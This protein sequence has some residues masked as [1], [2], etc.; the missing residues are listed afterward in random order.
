M[1]RSF[2]P[3]TDQIR[4]RVYGSTALPQ[5]AAA[6]FGSL[7]TLAAA[8]PIGEE[9]SGTGTLANAVVLVYKLLRELGIDEADIDVAAF[10]AL[11][12]TSPAVGLAHPA[13]AVSEEK[14]N[15]DLILRILQADLLR[16]FID[17]DGK[18]TI[19]RR[20]PFGAADSEIDDT[21]ILQNSIRYTFNYDD[22]ASIVSL[23]Y[24]I[25]EETYRFVKATGFPRRVYMDSRVATSAEQNTARYLHLIQK[26]INYEVPLLREVDAD[27]VSKRLAYIF[28]ER[29]GRIEIGAKNEFFDSN[30]DDTVNVKRTALPGSAFEPLTEREQKAKILERRRSTESVNI[31]LDDQKGIEDNSGGW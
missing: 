4:C 12:P 19:T 26:T 27:I 14:T 18:W 17:Q 22:I 9:I 10:Q 30:I 20:A 5:I 21:S 24:L 1:P 16:L 8:L 7:D 15:K 23:K 3:S 31:V 6:D 13:E 2:N 11:E 25:G 28:A 29:K